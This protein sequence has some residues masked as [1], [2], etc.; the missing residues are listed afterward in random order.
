M[1]AL[2]VVRSTLDR[3]SLC[4]GKA[5]R[6]LSDWRRVYRTL[7]LRRASPHVEPVPGQSRPAR[8]YASRTASL[9]WADR[10][11]KMASSRCSNKAPILRKDRRRPTPRYIDRREVRDPQSRQVAYLCN[12]PSAQERTGK[13]HLVEVPSFQHDTFLEAAFQCTLSGSSR[14]ADVRKWAEAEW[15]ELVE[16]GH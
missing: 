2:A 15:P 5:I 12:H 9:V 3:K 1:W 16:S 4:G 10:P 7:Q 6:L 14:K 11:R 8:P 13:S